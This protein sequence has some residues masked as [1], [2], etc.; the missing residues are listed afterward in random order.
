MIASA[1]CDVHRSENFFVL[2]IASGDWEDLCAKTE[3]AE[4]S[5]KRIRTQLSVVRGN[6]RFVA[7]QEFGF[8]NTSIFD[9]HDADGSIFVAHR[10]TSFGTGRNVINLTCRQIRDIGASAAKS[11]ALLGLLTA[12]KE[13]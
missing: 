3:F 2:N 4:S 5:G 7:A 6:R 12:E 11:V 1:G 9:L 13:F 10:K 8:F